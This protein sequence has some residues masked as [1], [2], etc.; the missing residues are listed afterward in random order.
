MQ[1]EQTESG[2]LHMSPWRRW[3][4]PCLLM[5][6]CKCWIS[7]FWVSFLFLHFWDTKDYRTNASEWLFECNLRLTVGKCPS[8]LRG[9]LDAAGLDRTGHLLFLA[10]G[11]RQSMP[12]WSCGKWSKQGSGNDYLSDTDTQLWSVCWN[13]WIKWNPLV[14]SQET[15]KV[16]PKIWISH[17]QEQSTSCWNEWRWGSLVGREREKEPKPW[18]SSFRRSKPKSIVL[19]MEATASN[20]DSI[21]NPGRVKRPLLQFLRFQRGPESRLLWGGPRMQ[22]SLMAHDADDWETAQ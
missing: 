18:E 6:V 2:F 10:C 13:W 11:R 7:L 8:T 1:I 16:I 15:G 22:V 5:K 17:S 3:C 4:L 9:L 20:R 19:K 21:W 12:T 14:A